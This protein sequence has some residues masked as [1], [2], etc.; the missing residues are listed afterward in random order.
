MIR[1]LKKETE[2]IALDLCDKDKLF[3]CL[4]KKNK[5]S[6]DESIILIY[7]NNEYYGYVTNASFEKDNNNGIIRYKYTYTL[8]EE[9]KLFSDL[10]AIF[11]KMKGEGGSYIPIFDAEMQQIKYFAYLDIQSVKIN[12]IVEY[13]LPFF[14]NN[15]DCLFI[16]KLFPEIEK[17]EIY[18]F[19][20]IA[21]RLYK[22]LEMR[23]IPVVVYGDKWEFFFSKS[24]KSNSVKS[25]SIADERIMRIYAEGSSLMLRK[26]NSNLFG[27]NI[28]KEMYVLLDILK[29]NIFKEFGNLKRCLLQKNIFALTTFF[30]AWEELDF[31]TADEYYR[32]D[33]GLNSETYYLMDEKNPL[34]ER[35]MNIC[36]PQKE[37]NKL[38]DMNQLEIECDISDIVIEDESVTCKRFGRGMHTVYLIGACIIAGAF[39]EQEESFGAYI[40]KEINK[41]NKDYNVKCLFANV[42]NISILRKIIESLT[43]YE[44]DI[45]VLVTNNIF[46][47]KNMGDLISEYPGDIDMASIINQRRNNWFWDQPIHTNQ[48]GN[49]E[50]AKQIVKSY[51]SDKLKEVNN[52]VKTPSL[53]QIGK[54]FLSNSSENDIREYIKKVKVPKMNNVKIGCIVMNCNPM[55]NGHFYL[56]KQ[57]LRHVDFLYIFLVEEDK[58]IFSFSDRFESVKAV[59]QKYSKVKVVPSG[60]YILS[61]KTMP[62]YFEKAQKQEEIIDATYDLRI[63]GEKIA[64]ELN[65]SVRFVGEEPYDKI[66][67]QYNIAMKEILP[68][69]NIDLV[70]IPR[71]KIQNTAISASIVR[72]CLREGKLN[73]IKELVPDEVYIMIKNYVSNGKE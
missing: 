68:K 38:N 13:A 5:D 27:Y 60:R 4:L 15:P 71:L 34:I 10:Y 11:N 32:H 49:Q 30:P 33:I 53:V 47:E 23:K 58:S 64:P 69:Y 56:I 29:A 41:F 2:S 21:F 9:Y 57:A 16:E 42:F 26:G 63:F 62:I 3:N 17:V 7:D 65:I 40:Y 39:V 35:Q 28:G 44:G 8:G 22:I 70:E 46:Y 19:N 54:C 73:V 25:K 36:L 66:T 45:V 50:I 1:F 18:D 67:K 48:K 14:E 24:V 55:T 61:Y 51:L 52:S 20:E 43:L 37:K 72:K 31:F 6:K 12:G 59:T